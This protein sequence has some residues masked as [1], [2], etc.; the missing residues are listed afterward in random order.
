MFGGWQLD[1]PREGEQK[2]NLTA[3]C[4][5]PFTN[6]Y[7]QC[8]RGTAR[9]LAKAQSPRNWRHLHYR[10]RS[11]QSPSGAYLG[12]PLRPGPVWGWKKLYWF[13]MWNFFCWNLNKFLLK[14]ERFCKCI[15]E[16]Y[17]VFRYINMPLNSILFKLHSPVYFGKISHYE[18][19]ALMPS[20]LCNCT[21]WLVNSVA[22]L[23]KYHKNIFTDET[24][25]NH[26]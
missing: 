8:H 22:M 14:F 26:S 24:T 25:D 16:I 13:L 2:I 15:P 1:F 7:H 6:N 12:G 23:S 5:Q 19:H 18:V 17:P 11:S 21:E 3:G 20:W 4:A 9:N 10:H